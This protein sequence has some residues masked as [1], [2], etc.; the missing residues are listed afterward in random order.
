MTA[1][2]F[3]P[4]W[5]VEEQSALLR[6]TGSQWTGAYVSFG[7][8]FLDSAFPLSLPWLPLQPFWA[9]CDLFNFVPS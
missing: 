2:R 9:R 6:G 1:R 7:G 4:P 8:A 3:P 5:T